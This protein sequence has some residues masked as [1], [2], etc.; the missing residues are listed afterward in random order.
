LSPAQGRVIAPELMTAHRNL[1][2]LE[3]ESYRGLA[4]VHWTFSIENRAVGWLNAEFHGHFRE[5]LTHTGIRYGCAIP[6]YCLMPDPLHVMLWGFREDANLY[7]AARFLRKNTACALLP[8]RYQKQAYDHVLSEKES[9]RGAFEAVCF[10]IVENPV[11]AK[12]C[13]SSKEYAFSGSIIPG[14]PDLRIHEEGYWELF[15]KICH[16]LTTAATRNP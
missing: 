16:R 13:G 15:W 10:Y 4:A 9:E 2:R 11:R 6:A 1:P 5:V 8:A 3:P 14:Y 12:L 7:L